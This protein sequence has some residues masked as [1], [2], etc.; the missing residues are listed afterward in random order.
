MK[1]SLL[2]LSVLLISLLLTNTNSFAQN[3]SQ[4]IIDVGKITSW[5]RNDGYH[6]WLVNGVFNG[7]FPNGIP[8]GVVFSEGIN[9][10]GLVH[11]ADSQLVRANGNNYMS[12]T[13][14]VTRLFRVRTDYAT[15]DLTLDAAN[16]FMKDTSEV[17]PQDIQTLRY[18]YQTD[19]NQWPA[20]HGAPYYDVDGNGTYDPSV[21]IPGIPG[22]LQTIWINYN[23]DQ[24][25]IYGS[26]PVGLNI[27]ETYWA[28]ASP[29]SISS[30]IY[31]KVDIVYE[32]T[33]ATPPDAYIDSMYICQWNDTDIGNRLTISAAAIPC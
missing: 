33:S 29:D 14:P 6:D 26:D 28:Y 22:A 18:Q 11:D 17:T 4:S 5:V 24:T 23:D 25:P 12:G 3:P 21:D 32:G 27:Q 16:F 15:A 1:K 31:K 10:S 19:R 7:S 2:F 20:D 9:W 13:A 8:V 30:V